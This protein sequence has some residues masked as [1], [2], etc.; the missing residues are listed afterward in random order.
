MWAS[1]LILW[2]S[3]IKEGH[4]DCASLYMADL[5]PWNEWHH[6]T[7]PSSII[8]HR[9][10]VQLCCCMG[11]R[12]CWNSTINFRRIKVWWCFEIC[13]LMPR[14]EEQ[15]VKMC[16]ECCISQVW[17]CL[18]GETI[19]CVIPER[20]KVLTLIWEC[21]LRTCRLLSKSRGYST[22]K[23]GCVRSSRPGWASRLS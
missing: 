1:T 7:F 8:T 11:V 9:W 12:F 20:W 21:D 18:F 4:V 14:Y 23:W 13:C 15:K 6:V 10:C 5:P 19:E 2:S 16:T 17:P 3:V 22:T